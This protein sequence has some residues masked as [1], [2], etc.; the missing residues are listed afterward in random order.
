MMIHIVGDFWKEFLLKKQVR[1]KVWKKRQSI[2]TKKASEGKSMEKR[3]S[4]PTKKAS[5]GKSMEKKAK[6]SY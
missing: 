1:E 3:Q 4:I 5:E 6:S 2:P